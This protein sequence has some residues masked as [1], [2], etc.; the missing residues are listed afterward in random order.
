MVAAVTL[1]AERVV[2]HC[3]LQLAHFGLV[4]LFRFAF[5][6]CE[7]AHRGPKSPAGKPSVH[8]SHRNYHRTAELPDRQ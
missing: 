5:G 1:A 3:R 2:P 8:V 4:Q 7:G 6:E